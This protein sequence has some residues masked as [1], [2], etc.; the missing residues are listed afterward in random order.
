MEGMLETSA[1]VVML[2]EEGEAM[3]IQV[4]DIAGRMAAKEVSYSGVV[5]LVEEM[6]EYTTE[7]E[8]AEV[9]RCSAVLLMESLVPIV[10]TAEMVVLQ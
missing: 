8:E 3:A 7:M 5:A 6:A 4:T 9:W 1:K 2:T 10:A